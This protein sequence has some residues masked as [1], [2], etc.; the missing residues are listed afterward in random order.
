MK[1]ILH[2]GAGHP[3]L[4]L[5]NARDQTDFLETFFTSCPD[6]FYTAGA[7]ETR[8]IAL[9]DVGGSRTARYRRVGQANGRSTVQQKRLTYGDYCDCITSLTK[10]MK[11]IFG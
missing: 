10:E 8:F 9:D 4:P 2:E 1:I 5:N 6:I 7:N 11:N 3:P